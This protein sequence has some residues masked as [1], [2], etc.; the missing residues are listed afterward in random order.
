MNPFDVL[1][2]LLFV[3]AVLLGFRSGLLPQLGGIAGAAAGGLTAVWLLPIVEPRLAALDPTVRALAVLAGLIFAV[4]VGEG[5]GAAIGRWAGDKLGGGLLG[6]LDRVA[7]AAGGAIQGVLIIW[8]AG[9]LLAVGPLPS[10]ARA[11]QTSTAVRTLDKVLAPPTTFASALGR[12]LDAS[13][14]PDFFI[15]LEPLPRPPVDLPT[16]PLVQ[17]IAQAVSAGT[18]KVVAATCGLQS[19]GTGFSNAPGYVVTNAHVVAGGRTI[20][21]DHQGTLYD[22]TPVFFDP[23]LDVALLFVPKLIMIPLPFAT[24]DPDRGALGA[25]FGHPAGGPLTVIPTAVTGAYD[26]RGVDIYGAGQITRRIIEL[27][28]A[29][30]RG[31]SGGPFVLLDGTVG[32][33]V[34]AEARTDASVGY[35]LS[36]VAVAAAVGPAVGRTTAV[37]VGACTT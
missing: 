21:V 14:L 37:P 32:G 19:S 15:G 23:A 10:L 33:V 17:A 7:G 31:D 20:R 11:A 26:A 25:S 3:I 6:A 36:P 1:A 18:V 13:G 22:A 2:A 29:I 4:G 35:A 28:A 34:F 8:L 27:H 30:E 9:G 24:K 12:L 16:D 5:V